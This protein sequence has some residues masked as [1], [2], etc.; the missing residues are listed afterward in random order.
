M[1]FYIALAGIIFISFESGYLLAG[2]N[3]FRRLMKKCS[4]D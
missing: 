1:E 3:E 4:K 2:F